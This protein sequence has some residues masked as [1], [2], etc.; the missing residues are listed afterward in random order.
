VSRKFPTVF[1][2]WGDDV[3]LDALRPPV[4]NQRYNKF[5]VIE[6]PTFDVLNV[7]FES[8]LIRRR[9]AKKDLC[10]DQAFTVRLG[11]GWYWL[12]LVSH[13]PFCIVRV[14]PPRFNPGFREKLCG[15][16]LVP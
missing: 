9:E 3:G 8:C 10:W 16:I 13:T 7:G 2:C 1:T 15:G 12:A 5:S 4:W 6:K 11:A 14:T